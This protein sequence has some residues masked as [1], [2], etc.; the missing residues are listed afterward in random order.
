M[1]AP[2][3]TAVLAAVVTADA[4]PIRARSLAQQETDFTSEGSPPPGVAGPVGAPP[5]TDAANDAALR[6]TALQLADSM[7]AA[8]GPRTPHHRHPAAPAQ[9]GPGVTHG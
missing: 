8:Q 7:P 1:D 6:P 2:V 4:P 3:V 9:A 5:S